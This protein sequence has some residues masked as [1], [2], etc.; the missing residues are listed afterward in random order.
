MNGDRK[1]IADL[2]RRVRAIEDRLR[3]TDEVGA[4]P[5]SLREQ[6]AQALKDRSGDGIGMRPGTMHYERA[7]AVLAVAADW[8][9]AQPLD[10]R[11]TD[12]S[13]SW[14]RVQRDH[15]VRLLRGQS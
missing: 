6:V 8:L 1:T 12:K 14:A 15:Y 3:E 7:D 10:S 9:A 2:A 11:V 4:Q 5:P 13:W